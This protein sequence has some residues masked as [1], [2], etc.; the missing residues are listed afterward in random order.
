MLNSISGLIL[1]AY[2]LCFKRMILEITTL[3]LKR[4]KNPD[5]IRFLRLDLMDNRCE[6]SVFFCVVLLWLR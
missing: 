4:K 5:I 6:F 2:A 3:Q 1:Q